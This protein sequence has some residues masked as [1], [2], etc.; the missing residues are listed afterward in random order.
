[1]DRFFHDFFLWCH[2]PLENVTVRFDPNFPIS[3][4][5]DSLGGQSRDTQSNC[6][7]TLSEATDPSHHFSSTFFGPSISLSVSKQTWVAE[8]AS[9]YRCVIL[10]DKRMPIITRRIHAI[11]FEVIFARS[12]TF[13]SRRTAF[14]W[15]WPL[16]GLLLSIC[17]YAFGAGEDDCAC[18]PRLLPCQTCSTKWWSWFFQ[19]VTTS[20]WGANK[21]FEQW[22]TA[23]RFQR[24]V[25]V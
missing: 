11:S 2:V 16:E 18:C 23:I 12:L 3:R 24:S 1:M 15:P 8:F 14:S 6:M 20:R 19:R 25:G 13:L 9:R 10:T 17:V 21:E 4:R 5:R 7:D 22:H